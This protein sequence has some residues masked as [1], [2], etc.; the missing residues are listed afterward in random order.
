VTFY[1]GKSA[2]HLRSWSDQ[3]SAHYHVRAD[4]TPTRHRPIRLILCSAARGILAGG[5]ERG[6]LR[7]ARQDGHVRQELVRQRN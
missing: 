5:F 2:K 3:V 4:R 1:I 6:D 7:D